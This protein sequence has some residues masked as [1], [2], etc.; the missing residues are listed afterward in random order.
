MADTFRLKE[1]L[2][3]EAE[4][5]RIRKELRDRVDG[6][7][8]D[9]CWT[10]KDENDDGYIYIS[11]KILDTNETGRSMRIRRY[12]FYLAWKTI[13]D[14][15]KLITY[16]RTPR[17]ENPTHA[18]YKGFKQPYE[19][20]KDLIEVGWLTQQQADSWYVPYT[21]KTTKT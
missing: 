17:C 19:R 2:S 4:Y 10:L 14:R 18:Y 6:C 7:F 5:T 13:P 8:T 3:L 15:R 11:N 16:C 21:R 1:G 9:H 12:L 20:V